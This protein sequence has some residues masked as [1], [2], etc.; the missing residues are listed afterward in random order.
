MTEIADRYSRPDI[1]AWYIE[2]EWGDYVLTNGKFPDGQGDPF[3]FQSAGPHFYGNVAELLR[4]HK[5]NP[6]RV[7]DV[8][9]ASGRMLREL[10]K[11]YPRADEFVGCE[12]SPVFA[13][14]ARSILFSNPP[15]PRWLSITATAT[16][17][18]LPVLLEGDIT[19]FAGVSSTRSKVDLVNCGLE[20]L[21]RPKRHFDLI[22]C[23]NVIDRHPAPMDLVRKLSEALDEGGTL[24]LASPLDWRDSPADKA[25]WVDCL[26]DLLPGKDWTVVEDV[27]VDYVFRVSERQIVHYKSQVIL[28]TKRQG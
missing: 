25:H 14:L 21:S 2:N 7:M 11:L 8:G 18:R 5:L 10:I 23:L 17:R 27:S 15:L 26:T 1:V 20:E 3:G 16:G 28:A 24:C 12:P 13:A 9:S 6:R 22:T 19:N 4:K